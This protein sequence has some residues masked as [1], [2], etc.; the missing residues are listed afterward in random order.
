MNIDILNAYCGS[1]SIPGPRLS[2]GRFTIYRRPRLRDGLSQQALSRERSYVAS[3]ADRIADGDLGPGYGGSVGTAARGCFVPSERAG[4]GHLRCA[5]AP[6][7][8]QSAP[9]G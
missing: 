6:D 5:R 9:K 4:P 8:H 2:E 7:R 3:S 1:G